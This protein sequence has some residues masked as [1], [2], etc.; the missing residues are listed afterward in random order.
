MNK[1]DRTRYEKLT[2]LGCIVS[3]DGMR[4]ESPC[5]IHH[6]H[7]GGMGKKSANHITIGLCEKH[8][9]TGGYGVAVHAGKKAF[10]SKYGTEAELLA[11][12]NELIGE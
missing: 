4:C 3:V 6:L 10:E 8:H 9:R 1:A 5:E 12:T 2:E 11:R 7:G